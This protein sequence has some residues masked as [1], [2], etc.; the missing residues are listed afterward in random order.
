MAALCAIANRMVTSGF[1][2][3]RAVG[4]WVVPQQGPMARH[5]N[6]HHKQDRHPGELGRCL[7]RS[8]P[9]FAVVI[10]D[11]DSC[12]RRAFAGNLLRRWTTDRKSTRLNS[13]HSQISY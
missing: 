4:C 10:F 13:S 7:T 3:A 11:K 8:E 5:T 1:V 12:W 6:P 2:V 9:A